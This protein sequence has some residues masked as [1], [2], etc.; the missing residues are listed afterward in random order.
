MSENPATAVAGRRKR[1]ALGHIC[2]TIHIGI[3]AFIVLG[4]MLPQAA[5][6]SVYL[7]FLPAVIVQWQ[8]NKNSCVLNNTESLLRTGRW[9]SPDNDEEGAWLAGVA[10]GAFGLEL[11]PAQLDT[12]V[13]LVLILFWGLAWVHLLRH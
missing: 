1:D 10:R 5:L 11:R 4:W 3:M 6:L 12:F 13:Y 9:R 7:V 8:L 2:F